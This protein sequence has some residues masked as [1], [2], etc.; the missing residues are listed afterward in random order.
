[1]VER[2][3][4]SDQS[5]PVGE[6]LLDQRLVA[7][8][9]NMW[10]AETLWAVRVSPWRHLSEVSDAELAEALTWARDRMRES[11]AGNRPPRNVYRRAG[12]SCPRC[13]TQVSSRGLGARQPHGV[14]VRVLPA[15][16]S[17]RYRI[18]KRSSQDSRVREDARDVLGVL[19]LLVVG[20]THPDAVHARCDAARLDP[21]D[22]VSV[23]RGHGP[24]VDRNDHRV[25]IHAG[26]GIRG[27]DEERPAGSDHPCAHA[28]PRCLDVV[29]PEAEGETPRSRSSGAVEDD[30][31]LARRRRQR[32]GREDA[33]AEPV[34]VR[35]LVRRQARVAGQPVFV[36]PGQ[37]ARLDQAPAAAARDD[38]AEVRDATV[39]AEAID[40]LRAAQ[41]GGDSDAAR[42]CGIAVARDEGSPAPRVTR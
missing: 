16:R 27:P 11:V 31:V 12:R 39:E 25:R 10:L 33:G 23:A 5:R 18:V 7:G 4:R 26:A 37:H 42:A 20:D 35:V 14:L 1:M 3:R 21:D 34:V 22:T 8:I 28:Q 15:L 24:S 40:P 2:M 13:G 41:D 19:R 30:R 32:P 17:K 38:H 9:G 29:H 6:A 36:E